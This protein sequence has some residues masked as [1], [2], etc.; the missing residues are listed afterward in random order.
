MDQKARLLLI[1]ASVLR[2]VLSRA[3]PDHDVL[4]A[5]H[6]LNGVWKSGRENF[7]NALVSLSV[8]SKALRVVSSLRQVSPGMRIVVSCSPADEPVARQ[9]LDEGA[10]DYVLEPLRREDVELA[11]GLTP[12][13]LLP[14]APPAAGPSL[15]EIVTLGNVLRDLDDGALPTLE[16]LAGLLQQTF[17]AAG[18]SLQLDDL[19]C[20]AGDASE[21]VLEEVIRRAGK[22]V[23]QV[24]LA[25]HTLGT[26]ATDTARRLAEYACLIEA[27]VAQAQERD[28]WRQLAWTDDLSGLHNRRYFDQTLDRLIKRALEKRLRLTVLLFDIDDFKSYNDR[29]GHETG[30]KLIQE[31]ARLLRQCTRE[32]DVV[33]R[34]GG[35][36]FA[37]V[38]W[39]AEK[40]R[41]PG[42]DHPHEP[43]ELATR[44]CKAIARH[45]FDC[46]GNDAPGPVTI[47][48][49]LACFPWNGNTRELLM[50]AADEALLVAKRTGKNGIRLAGKGAGQEE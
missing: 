20:V 5:E 3:L 48:G 28:H 22:P 8:G 46:L 21:I 25:R 35:D 31:V 44:F 11:F 50:A 2:S 12:R 40:Q 39:D 24:G 17:G 13:R 42:S 32:R 16:R 34:Y 4:I 37:V 7:D 23:G 9:A 19:T 36:E 1:G 26:Y 33:V 10:D 18:V 27:T 47:S 14:E 43:M 41:V 29:F 49:G 38:F 15:R 6:A 30:D 45:D